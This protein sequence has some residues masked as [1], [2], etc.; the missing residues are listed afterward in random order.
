METNHTTITLAVLHGSRAGDRA[1]E[2]SDWDVAVLSDHVLTSDDRARLRRTFASRFKVPDEKIDVAD[3]R[4]DSPLLRYRVAMH[5][6]LL[7]GSR[8]A[9][10]RFQIGAWKDYLNN[11]KI[12]SLRTRFLKTALR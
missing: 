9:W 11:E 10:R 7:D 8:D 3:L 5:G 2:S 1:N 4:I 6:T 12:F